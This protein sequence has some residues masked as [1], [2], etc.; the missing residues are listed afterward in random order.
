MGVATLSLCTFTNID[1]KKRAR[2]E[3]CFRVESVLLFFLLGLG[4]DVSARGEFFES[5]FCDFNTVPFAF[6]SR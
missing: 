2:L 6:F 4:A 1:L 3:C 5:D